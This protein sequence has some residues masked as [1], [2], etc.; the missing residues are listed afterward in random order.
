[1]DIVDYVGELKDKLTTPATA[2]P[3][4]SDTEAKIAEIV[5][6]GDRGRLPKE[7]DPVERVSYERAEYTPPTDDEI[8][9]LAKSE[10][11]D[12]ER[13]GLDGIQ[14]EIESL[15][16]SYSDKR[17]RAG[18]SY[19]ETMKKLDA[20]YRRAVEAAE[21]DAIKRGLARSSIAAL[22]RA[23]IERDRA[24]K[25]SAAASLKAGTEAEIDAAIGELEAKRQKAIADFNLSYF[26][27]LSTQI[28]KKKQEREKAKSETLKYNNS[29]VAKENADEIAARKAESA[30]RS[31]ALSQKKKE[32][33]L[34][35]NPSEEQKAYE[36]ALVYAILREKLLSFDAAT[37]RKEVKTNP[38]FSRYVSNADYYKLYDEFGR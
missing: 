14:S 20:A 18:E 36:S 5:G 32:N 34:L 13:E 35:D 9:S 25:E 26:A 12:Y 29:L 17:S 7:P 37:A 22:S 4:Y 31:D 21:A 28:E 6:G 38:L 27:K 11:A 16:K 1:M 2:N 23:E 19:D 15:V 3:D 24:D 10:L 8:A 30:L 33:D